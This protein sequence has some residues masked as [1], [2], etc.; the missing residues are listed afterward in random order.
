MHLRQ[1]LAILESGTTCKAVREFQA[2]SNIAGSNQTI[3]NKTLR[4]KHITT[5]LKPPAKIK[6]PENPTSQFLPIGRNKSSSSSG[7]GEGRI[8]KGIKGGGGGWIT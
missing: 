3:R 2:S 7:M 1:T 5:S 6:G 8:H 4:L